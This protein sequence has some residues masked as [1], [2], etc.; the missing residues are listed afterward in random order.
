MLWTTLHDIRLLLLRIAY[1]EPL[2]SDSGGGSLTS[3]VMLCFYQLFL[4]DLLGKDAEHDS[5][6]SARQARFLPGGF[7]V[8]MELVTRRDQD[9]GCGG[10]VTLA[11]GVADASIMAGLCSILFPPSSSDSSG[12]NRN[13]LWLT[14][15]L[16]FLRGFIRCA[17]RRFSC[18]VN[19]SGCISAR[20][21]ASVKRSRSNISSFADWDSNAMVESSSSGKDGDGNTITNPATVSG[22]GGDKTSLWEDAATAL[23]PLLTLFGILDQMAHGFTPTMDDV[24]VAE[25]TER[26]V[27]IVER[28]G[29]AR[30]LCELMEVVLKTGCSSS[31]GSTGGGGIVLGRDEILEEFDRGRK[32]V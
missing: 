2:N 26:I 9:G 10:S 27:H 6:V 5:P 28:C 15:R 30:G 7:I 29:K 25:S 32:S 16:C 8:A 3:N 31:E 12:S 11:R 20:A 4:A 19:D 22:S 13:S 17:G 23:R 1:G 21:A 24:S 14:H 18:G